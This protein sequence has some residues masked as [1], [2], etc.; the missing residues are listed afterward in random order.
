M[1]F[2]GDGSRVAPVLFAVALT[3]ALILALWWGFSRG[4]RADAAGTFVRLDF[5]R[6]ADGP[7]PGRFDT[8]QIASSSNSP[9]DPG[10]NFIVRDGRLTYQPTTNEVSA[11]YFSTPDMGAPVTSLGASWVLSPGQG[12]F[13][14]VALVVSRGIKDPLPRVVP[15]IPVHLVITAVNWHFSIAKDEVTP[16]ETIAEGFF[17][18]PLKEDSATSYRV[19]IYIDGEEATINLPDGDRRTVKDPR[20]SEWQGNV[21]TFEVYSNHGL[22]DSIGGFERIWADSTGNR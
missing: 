14:A 11:A 10:S 22:T 19:S 8:G 5:A 16:L 1:N 4:G 3:A 15:P 20:I 9:T 18:E 21:A 2:R 7:P 17:K 13:G 6:V 12:T